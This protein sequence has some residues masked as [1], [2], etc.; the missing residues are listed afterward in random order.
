MRERD[1]KAFA[2]FH[3]LQLCLSSIPPDQEIAALYRTSGIGPS[4]RQM[5]DPHP[6]ALDR[7][8]LWWLLEEVCVGCENCVS[9]VFREGRNPVNIGRSLK[10]GAQNRCDFES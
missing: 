3:R 5:D 2:G 10:A 4:C 7:L 1:R 9:T 6:R 8:N